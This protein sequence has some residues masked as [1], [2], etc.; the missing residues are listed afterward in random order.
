VPRLYGFDD[1][2]FQR[3]RE[4][5]VPPL[6]QAASR[7]LERQPFAEIT[8]WMNSEGYRT[9]RGGLWR[10]GVLANV[11][12][13]PAI[14]GLREDE[15]GELVPTGGPAAI[16]PEEFKQI[17]A[18]RPVNDPEKKRRP[19]REYL[20]S[21]DMCV[22]GLCSCA[23]EASPSGS[24]NRGYRCA[25]GTSRRPG[26][27][28]KVRIN[29]D[30]LETYVAED[31]VAELAKP[32][33][34]ALLEVARKQ[35][36]AEAKQLRGEVVGY[37]E[38]QRELGAEYGRGEISGRSFRA[39]DQELASKIRDLSA[40]ARVVEQV[41]L[42]PLG[43]VRDVARWWEHAPMASKKGLATLML[44]RVTVFPASSRGSRTVDSSRVAL[45]W[46]TWARG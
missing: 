44:E 43:G 36:L 9:T 14:A 1:M 8:E 13:H 11:L 34:V 5:E 4:A 45:K 30:L 26:G 22:C 41:E 12:D 24:G 35:V 39:A 15:N 31:L 3:L 18:L 16:S 21:A 23:L 28:G 10:P 33:V 6:R 2:S 20:F 19:Q 38:R 29:A 17:R 40:R 27:C 37:Q 46:R 32:E 7:R 42:V 25:P